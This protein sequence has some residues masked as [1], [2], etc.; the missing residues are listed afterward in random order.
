MTYVSFSFM[1][2]V[3]IHGLRHVINQADVYRIQ[4]CNP[5][6]GYNYYIKPNQISHQ[7]QVKL[8]QRQGDVETIQCYSKANPNPHVIQ[9]QLAELKQHAT[10]LWV[11][12]NLV[13]NLGVPFFLLNVFQITPNFWYTKTWEWSGILLVYIYLSSDV[14]RCA[15][16]ENNV[17][18]D[19]SAKW[20]LGSGHSP[21]SP[22]FNIFNFKFQT[23][24][25]RFLR[26]FCSKWN[27]VCI[28]WG[29]KLLFDKFHQTFCQTKRY[30]QKKLKSHA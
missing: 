26:Y 14:K 15:K 6:V 21:A 24:K 3:Q 10:V 1:H 7:E 22:S 30:I 12:F 13:N 18:E 9:R 19:Q 2:C 17:I 16:V 29:W 27:T 11:D 8:C 20:T 4:C 5:P 28:F 25:A 23:I